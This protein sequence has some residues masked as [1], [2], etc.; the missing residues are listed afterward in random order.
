MLAR[1]LIS[2]RIIWAIV[3]GAIEVD[4]RDQAD[5]AQARTDAFVGRL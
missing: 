2:L 3:A 1:K 4:G 5:I